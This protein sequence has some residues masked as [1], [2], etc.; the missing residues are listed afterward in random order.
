MR[1]TV[2]YVLI[3][4]AILPATGTA[5]SNHGD[6]MLKLVDGFKESGLEASEWQVT[7]KE[8][9]STEDAENVLNK[10]KRQMNMTETTDE[11]SEIHQATVVDQATKSDISYQVILP[12]SNH[13]KA[14]IIVSINGHK[15]G[16]PIR[17]AYQKKV[18]TIKKEFF[19]RHSKTFACLT[20]GVHDTISSVYLLDN[21]KN[22]YKANILSKQIDSNK[23]SMIKDIQYGYTPLWKENIIIDGKPVNLQFVIKETKSDA[24]EI[25]VG[26]PILINEY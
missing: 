18:N 5:E 13:F 17:D 3:L 7:I 20:G 14:E 9:V 15:W 10:L 25:T 21:V 23:K 8:N 19:T 16:E 1:K 4:L 12:E 11:N 22:A 2:L 24:L 26:T 6:V